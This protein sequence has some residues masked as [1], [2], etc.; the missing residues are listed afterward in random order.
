MTN[1]VITLRLKHKLRYSIILFQKTDKSKVFHSGKP[2]D[3]RTKSKQYMEKT[4]A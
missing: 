2:E 4:R 3:Y 1:N